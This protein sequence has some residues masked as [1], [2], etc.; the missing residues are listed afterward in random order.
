MHINL[1][2]EPTGGPIPVK[3]VVQPATSPAQAAS[4]PAPAAAAQA[5]ESDRAEV[6]SKPGKARPTINLVSEDPP[7]KGAANGTGS[8]APA[9]KPRP[10]RPF[11]L[12]GVEVGGSILNDSNFFVKHE[13]DLGMTTSYGAQLGLSISHIDGSKSNLF[14]KNRSALHTQFLGREGTLT[15]QSLLTTNEL[16]VGG[17]TNAGLFKDPRFS[18][19]GR[20]SYKGIDTNPHSGWAN[21]QTRL[22][23][24]ANLRQYQNHENP[25]VNDQAYLTPMATLDFED[26]AIKG[27]L[28]TKTEADAGLGTM[29]PLQGNQDFMTPLR[30]DASG[31]F[32]FGY[33]YHDK[34]IVYLKMSGELSNDPLPYQRDHGTLGS[35]GLALGNEFRL[36]NGKNMDL[37][38]GL[39]TR[40]IQPFGNLGNNPLP[41]Q[42]GKHD[43]IHE[44]FNLK[45][46]IALK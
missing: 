17:R 6:E 7:A 29:I 26:E 20:L 25:F 15:H 36:V 9:A 34:S 39:E 45:V 24:S 16:E 46:K 23:E 27:R 31:S 38:L 19:G 28:Y 43:L 35:F 11:S 22:H 41:N 2:P 10:P 1:T 44:M 30:A 42:T 37:N 40:V 13:D 14:F 3:P 21:V 8:D 5:V 18:V 33:A 4:E 32:K 12:I